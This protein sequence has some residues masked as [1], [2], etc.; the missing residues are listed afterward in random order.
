MKSPS[1]Q[2]FSLSFLSMCRGPTDPGVKFTPFRFG[3]AIAPNQPYRGRNIKKERK[4][5]KRRSLAFYDLTD[6]PSL[7]SPPS[8]W[9]EEQQR[10]PPNPHIPDRKCGLVHAA[11]TTK[12]LL[13]SFFPEWE[14]VA[15]FTVKRGRAMLSLLYSFSEL[16]LRFL[17]VSPH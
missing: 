3:V 2:F 15:P 13:P 9:K 6:P 16:T 4:E 8:L 7:P 5:K 14:N 12:V 1:T 11:A 17:P 10:P